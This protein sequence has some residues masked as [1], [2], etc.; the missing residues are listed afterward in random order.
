MCTYVHSNLNPSVI[1]TDVPRPTGVE[2]VCVKVQ[3][4]KWP[5]IIIG[6]VYRHPK[7][8]ATS[9]DYSQDVFR[10]YFFFFFF[11]TSWPVAPVGFLEGPGGLP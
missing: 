10:I 8:L 7:A 1:D 4:K 6:C 11:F 3:H 5:A 9:F 2:D